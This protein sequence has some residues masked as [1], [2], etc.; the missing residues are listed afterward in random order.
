MLQE[1]KTPASKPLMS[2]DLDF[3]VWILFCVYELLLYADEIVVILH[4][5]SIFITYSP[6]LKHRFLFFFVTYSDADT[7]YRQAILNEKA[8]VSLTLL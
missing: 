3:E 1:T 2:T 8:C 6:K 7:L 5:S 4:I